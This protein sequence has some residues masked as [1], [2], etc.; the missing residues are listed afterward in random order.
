[1]CDDVG[2]RV[3]RGMT[4]DRHGRPYSLDPYGSLA[5]MLAEQGIFVLSGSRRL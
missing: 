1:M 2:V 5:N 3:E 4:L